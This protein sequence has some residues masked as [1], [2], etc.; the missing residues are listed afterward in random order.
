TFDPNNLFNPGKIVNAPPLASNLRYGVGY[1]AR[2][3]QTTFDFSADG[4]VL[5]SAELCSGV[6]ACRKKRE[7]SM[8]PS[9]QATRDE[10]H[11]TRGLNDKVLGID[12][13]RAMPPVGK[14]FDYLFQ[15]RP[16][17]HGFE[18]AA[19]GGG[20]LLFPDTFVGFYEPE[21]AL[22]AINLFQHMGY[23]IVPGLPAG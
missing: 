14:A 5:R 19:S 18:K 12:Q 4:G 16:L 15:S 2:E 9:Y 11:T 20:A 10:Q 17:W 13:R 7:G 22:A 3:I 6:G 23:P 8:C 21:I 1:N